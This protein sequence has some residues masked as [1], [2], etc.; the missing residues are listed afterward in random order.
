MAIMEQII[1]DL[2]LAMKAKEQLR[3]DTLRMAKSALKNREI[4][5]GHPLDDAEAIKVLTTLVKQRRE[6]AEQFIKGNRPELADKELAEVKFIEAYLPVSLSEAE[7][8]TVVTDTIRELGASNAK[9]TGAVMKAVMAKL[10]GQAVDGKTV[11]MLVRN[12]LAS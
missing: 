1:K 10:A 12:K 11:N 2:T 4:D 6:A 7:I 8:E 5:A 9:D 3:L